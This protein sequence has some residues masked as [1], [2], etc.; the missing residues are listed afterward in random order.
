MDDPDRRYIT[1]LVHRSKLHQSLWS[2]LHFTCDSSPGSKLST[3][4]SLQHS[5]RLGS[6]Q[7]TIWVYGQGWL[8]E[9]D[10]ACQ[11]CMW[12]KKL[13]PQFL[14]SCGHGS[15]FYDRA[16]HIL[17]SHH[18]QPF[19][20]KAGD[21]VNDQ[22]NDNAPNLKLKGLYGQSTINWQIQHVNPKF[23]N[24]HINAVLVETWRSFQI[25]S[26]PI[27]IN[28]FKKR[29]IVPLTPHDEDTKTQACL[30]AAQTPKGKK[31]EEIKVIARASINPEDV[32]V[33]RTT[34]TMVVLRDKVNF[35]ASSNLLMRAAAYE[36][37][38]HRTLLSLQKIR[39]TEM[40]IRTR[41]MVIFPKK[42]GEV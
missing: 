19:V 21:S 16:I 13:N 36:N 20:L 15:H 32:V 35:G 5:E 10:D 33:I 4:Y 14:F 2:V 6:P 42:D 25:S 11:Y 22:P 26:A 34:D 37:F 9:V 29:N 8:D 1:L 41:I 18:I 12:S 3:R 23:K 7:Y 31:A 17:H 27:I 40:V 30:A 39:E 24:Y 28:S 38:R